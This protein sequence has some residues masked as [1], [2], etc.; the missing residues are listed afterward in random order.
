MN[1]CSSLFF[2]MV[3]V[4]KSHIPNSPTLMALD[5]FLFSIMLFSPCVMAFITFHVL[6]VTQMVVKICQITKILCML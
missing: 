1:F 3:T 5:C 4:F 2:R 6:Y